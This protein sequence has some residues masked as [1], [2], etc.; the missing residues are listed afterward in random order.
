M[1]MWSYKFKRALQR[2]TDRYSYTGA[3]VSSIAVGP[4]FYRLP[5]ARDDRRAAHSSSAS[6]SPSV[7]NAPGS[8]SPIQSGPRAGYPLLRLSA[9]EA[10]RAEGSITANF[11]RRHPTACVLRPATKRE[12]G[13]ERGDGSGALRISSGGPPSWIYR[14]TSVK[15]LNGGRDREAGPRYPR[16]F[17]ADNPKQARRHVWAS[18]EKGG[19]RRPNHVDTRPGKKSE[20]R[21]PSDAGNR[22]LARS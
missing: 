1:S 4:L 2:G 15:R 6:L 22:E 5:V 14:V 19:R 20:F 9:A 8:P 7:N 21:P 11:R 10:H 3:R 16:P 13:E 18:S 12:K 17:P